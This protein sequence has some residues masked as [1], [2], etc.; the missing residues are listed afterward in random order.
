MRIP[1]SPAA[2]QKITWSSPYLHAGC[3]LVIAEWRTPNSPQITMPSPCYY[4]HPTIHASCERTTEKS[5]DDPQVTSNGRG[6]IQHL[7]WLM[8]KKSINEAEVE[9]FSTLN[10]YKLLLTTYICF[11]KMKA[12]K[13]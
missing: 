10:V 2:V 7:L 1:R 8:A 3:T 6:R 4:W 12:A 13:N 5:I 9:A 11:G